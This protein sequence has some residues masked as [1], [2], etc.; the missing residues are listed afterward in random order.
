VRREH[1]RRQNEAE[2][3]IDGDAECESGER[4]S[5]GARQFAEPGVRPM[6]KKQ[7]MNAQVRRSLIGATKVGF[8]ILL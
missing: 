5:A 7:K 4:F 1:Q 3:H 2:R 6:L 8:T